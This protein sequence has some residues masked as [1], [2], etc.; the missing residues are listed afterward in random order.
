MHPPI[1][2]LEYFVA[3]ADEGQFTR[4]AARL[5][6]AQ[7]SVSAQVRQLELTLG[8]SLFHRGSGPVT[9]TDAGEALLPIARRVLTDVIE[10]VNE[11]AEVEGLRRGHVGIGATPSLSATLLPVVLGR[12]HTSH[13]GVS[14]A[15]SEQGSTHLLKGLASGELDLALAVLPV[16]EQGIERTVLA[17]EE[18]VVA[19]SDDHPLASRQ[20]IGI[21][22]LADIPMVM[23]RDGYDLRTTTLAAFGEA[24]L[25]PRIAVE[26]GEMGSVISLAAEGLGAAIIPSIVAITDSRLHILRLDRPSLTREIALVSRLDRRPSN[27]ASALANEIISSLKKHGWPHPVPLGLSLCP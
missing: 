19:I 8:T 6:V 14:I 2:Q 18:L 13:P 17:I 5:H 26:G 16:H 23:F 7:P 25:A 4:A 27:A 3:V 15:V 24:G 10:L 21:S 22:D 1:H 11:V 12:F 9:L 20:R